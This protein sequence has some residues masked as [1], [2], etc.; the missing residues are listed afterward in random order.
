MSSRPKQSMSELKL[1]RLLEHNQRLREDLGRPRIRVSEASASLI[2][3]CK[4][5]TDHLVSSLSSLL[6]LLQSISQSNHLPSFF[7]PYPPYLVLTSFGICRYRRC[8]AP[9]A[10]TRIHTHQRAVVNAASCN[11]KESVV[12]ATCPSS[13]MPAPATKRARSFLLSH[14]VLQIKLPHGII[15]SHQERTLTPWSL[16]DE[17]SHHPRL[18]PSSPF[19]CADAFSPRVGIQQR[20]RHIQNIYV[21]VHPHA[22]THNHSMLQA[23][24]R[25]LSSS[26]FRLLT[27]PISAI[28]PVLSFPFFLYP[29]LFL[30]FSI[31]SLP[32]S[33]FFVL[34]PLPFAICHT[35]CF[36]S[37]FVVYTLLPLL[38]RANFRFLFIIFSQDFY[39]RMNGD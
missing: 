31:L 9:S 23:T 26:T 1:R 2:R 30:H 13:P 18:Q 33:T 21:H 3:Y 22:Y 12:V 29:V 20:Y 34:L 7:S 25:H 6:P 5:T 36:G 28:Y 19:S 14:F 4:T 39:S 10:R 16:G 11:E 15:A 37:S 38:L 35:V 27:L 32:L 8:G 17:G 24:D